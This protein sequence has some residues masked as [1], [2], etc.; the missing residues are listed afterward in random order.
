MESDAELGI[1]VTERHSLGLARDAVRNWVKGVGDMSRRFH[2]I[3][4]RR[5]AT[6]KGLRR[7]LAEYE[8]AIR[9]YA[10]HFSEA[11]SRRSTT[12]IFVTPEYRELD[13]R[14]WQLIERVAITSNLEGGTATSRPLLYLHMHALARLFLRLQATS[15]KVVRS[16]LASTLNICDALA[17]AAESVGCRQVLLPTQHG[18]FRC[19]V[20]PSETGPVLR[21]KTWISAHDWCQRDKALAS[22]IA[23]AILAWGLAVPE[24]RKD[25]AL[26]FGLDTP[27][28]DL[29]ATISRTLRRH[30]WLREPYVER[31][32]RRKRPREPAVHI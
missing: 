7:L 10:F 31:R 25:V 14:D 11:A 15:F 23:T 5:V 29:V 22:E 3:N 28:P 6:G 16:E 21:A 19:D 32:D 8:R 30:A 4:Q 13:G 12:Q 27:P 9:P 17:V 26:N 20:E 1:S 24:E 18:V 2:D